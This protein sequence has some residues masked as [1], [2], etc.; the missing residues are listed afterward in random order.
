ME[1]AARSNSHGEAFPD[2]RE[3]VSR[4]FR[5]ASR[6]RKNAVKIKAELN[7]E[8]ETRLRE[9]NENLVVA[10][11][12]AQV[13]TE[14][15]EKIL[16]HLSHMAEHDLLTGLPNRALLTD[17]LVQ[18]ISLAKRHGNKLALMFLDVDHFKDI[19]DSMGHAIGDQL[20]QSVAKR[21]QACVRNSD[22]VSRHGGDEFVVLLPEVG[23]MQSVVHA[24]EK[25]IQSVGEPHLISGQ[26]LHVTLSIGIS[27]YPNDGVDADVLM[28]NA[29]LAMYQAK[30]AGRNSYRIFTPSMNTRALARTP[31]WR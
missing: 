26:K 14:A 20:L 22:T 15:I 10:S 21:L 31:S 1:Q 11:V 2:R 7:A 25:L 24:A 27:M 29:D 4:V 9:A 13:M 12:N 30:K 6:S 28:R 3:H 23:E 19:N 8:M 5:T 16:V 17:R 18:S